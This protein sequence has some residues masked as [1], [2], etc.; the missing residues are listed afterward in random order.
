M[1]LTKGIISAN[2]SIPAV[3]IN[4]IYIQS[5]LNYW[6]NDKGLYR[7]VNHY[8]MAIVLMLI[9]DCNEVWCYHESLLVK[10]H[11]VVI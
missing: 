11:I 3:N 10:I 1:C 7:I 6:V 9:K 5:P 2:N 4:V 8:T